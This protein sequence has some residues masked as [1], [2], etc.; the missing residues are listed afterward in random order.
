VNFCF[1]PCQIPL[2]SQWAQD[3]FSYRIGV[4]SN[5]TERRKKKT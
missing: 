2:L 3:Q 1:L 4:R 5:H